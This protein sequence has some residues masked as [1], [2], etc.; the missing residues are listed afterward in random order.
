MDGST[1]QPD[2][3]DAHRPRGAEQAPSAMAQELA[4]VMANLKA[5]HATKADWLQAARSEAA[6][7]LDV[8]VKDWNAVAQA[9][10][11]AMA[12]QWNCWM[13]YTDPGNVALADGAFVLSDGQIS[14]LN[15]LHGQWRASYVRQEKLAHDFYQVNGERERIQAI[16]DSRAEVADRYFDAR[17]EALHNYATQLLTQLNAEDDGL[18]YGLPPVMEDGNE[19]EEDMVLLALEPLILP[20]DESVADLGC[21]AVHSGTLVGCDG[22]S[23]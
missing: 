23:I 1:A 2:M 5:L 18:V 12:Q 21:S 22:W 9:C 4:A 16:H 11:A 10:H 17:I 19:D 6:Q 20:G 7:W 3:S 15:H 13:A 14:A 8:V